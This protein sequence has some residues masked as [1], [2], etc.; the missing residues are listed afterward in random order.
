MDL[1]YAVGWI[2][3]FFGLLVPIPQL[4][5]ILRSGKTSD[6]SLGTYGFLCICLVLY[7]IHAIYIKSPVFITAQS[8]NL[9][10]NS[11]IFVLLIRGRHAIRRNK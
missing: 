8:I 1:G 10:T 3:V 7:L 11:F 9:I 6:I 5:K 2:G 4:I